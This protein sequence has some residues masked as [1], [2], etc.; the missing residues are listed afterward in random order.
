MSRR[1]LEINRHFILNN[2]FMD[3]KTSVLDDLV[4]CKVKRKLLVTNV[5]WPNDVATSKPIHIAG[6]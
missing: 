6:T 3:L 1:N 5:G 4:V 2:Q